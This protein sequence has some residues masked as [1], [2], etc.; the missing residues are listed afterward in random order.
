MQV[1]VDTEALRRG[2]AEAWRQV[3]EAMG[4][5]LL[6]YATRLTGSRSEAEEVVQDALVK[7]YQAIGEFEGRCSVRS[8]LYRAV[9]NRAIDSIRRRRRFV[10]IGHDDEPESDRFD[11]RGHWTDPVAP[12]RDAAGQRIDA[13]RMLKL[14]EQAM[15]ELPHAHREVLLMKEVHGLSTEEICDALD[16]SAGNLRI[17]LHRARKALRAQ[18]E[19]AAP[20]TQGDDA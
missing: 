9:H 10:D 17:R 3:L 13:Q 6:G 11:G 1:D 7:V 2:D 15:N 14:V 18:V 16:I 20:G 12:W 5:G 4:P 8:W 19:T